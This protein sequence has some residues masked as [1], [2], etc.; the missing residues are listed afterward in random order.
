MSVN[1]PGSLSGLR[2][3][4]AAFEAD[5]VLDAAEVLDMPVIEL[6]RTVADPDHMPRGRVPVARGGI[7]AR[8][9]L[10]VAEQQRLVAGVEF[11]RAQFRVALEIEAAGAHEIQRIGNAVRQ[12]LVTARLLRILDEAEHPLMHA[13]EI[14]EAAGRERAQQVQRRRRLAVR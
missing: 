11:R 1:R 8:E 12:F 10:L 6:A 13:A 3:R 7:D 4:R 14:G 2:V 5:R 9:R